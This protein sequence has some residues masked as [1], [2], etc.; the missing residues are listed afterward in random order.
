[1]YAI[2]LIKYRKPFAEVEPT[3]AAHRAYLGEL[4]K[5]G[6]LLASGPFEPRVG[7][8]VLF[9][10]PDEGYAAVLDAIVAN[11]PYVKAGLA[12]WEVWPWNAGIGK[13]DLDRI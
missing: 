1:M 12:Q 9:R 7:G 13:E 8:A 2:G 10:V 5:R 3:L 6:T 11:D 4:K